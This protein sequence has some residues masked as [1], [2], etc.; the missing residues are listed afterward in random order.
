VIKT[1]ENLIAEFTRLY[2]EPY[3]R[4]QLME[5]EGEIF[6]LK[7]GLYETDK[8][9]D[10]LTL[11]SSIYGPSYISF[12]TA[13]SYYD[14]IPERSLTYLSASFGSKKKKMFSNSYGTFVYQDIT[15]K[16]FPVGT[17]F[18][19]SEGRKFEIATPEKALCDTV[20]KFKPLKNN[21]E[22]EE[23]L[24]SF[25]RMEK[26]EILRLDASSISLWAPLYEQ[27]NVRLLADYLKEKKHEN[28]IG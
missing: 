28:K 18:V 19:D 12:E 21:A 23:W 3:H 22:L 5:R 4:L 2:A 8:T 20:S 25:M 1:S 16:A 17:K 14:L 13:L 24:Y 27:K 7:R 6:R 10:P 11:A 15:P 26:D 9:A